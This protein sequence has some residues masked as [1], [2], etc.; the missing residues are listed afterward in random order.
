ML[1]DVTLAEY[2]VELHDQGRAPASASTAG[3]RGAFP[4]GCFGGGRGFSAGNRLNAQNG[5]DS[6]ARAARR[7]LARARSLRRRFCGA[8]S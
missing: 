3:G 7:G 2:L 6:A 1:E 8:D 4:G 5:A